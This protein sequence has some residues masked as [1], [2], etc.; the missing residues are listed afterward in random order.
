MR[1]GEQVGGGREA[2]DEGA[3]RRELSVLLRWTVS[4]LPA[5]GRHVTPETLNTVARAGVVPTRPRQTPLCDRGC[6]ETS[7]GGKSEEL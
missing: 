6:R 2:L 1:G 5:L 3:R 4:G 7:K